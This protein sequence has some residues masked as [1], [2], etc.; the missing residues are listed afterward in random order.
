[1]F[2]LSLKL[3]KS[4]IAIIALAI[5]LIIALVF[6]TFRK[7]G[8]NGKTKRDRMAYIY[9]LG[10]RASNETKTEIVIPNEFSE[11]FNEYN[12]NQI[13]AGFDLSEHKGEKAILYSYPL[14]DETD[15]VYLNLIVI[16]GEIIGGDVSTLYEDGFTLPLIEK[17]KN[18]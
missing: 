15:E 9:S 7:N 5:V 2:L 4:R 12:K 3:K 17:N 14:E 6:G 18:F 16:E 10:Y 8:I 11:T 1:M 13:L